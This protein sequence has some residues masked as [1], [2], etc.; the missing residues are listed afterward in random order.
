MVTHVLSG[1]V[2]GVEGYCVVVEADVSNGLPVFDIGGNLGPEVKE[3]RER[4]R[5][6]LKNI[7]YELP[8][9]RITVNFSPADRRKFGTAYDLPIAIAVLA[10]MKV[11]DKKVLEDTFFAG[12]LLLTGEV[13]RVNG[14]LP[15]VISAMRN[16]C[17]RFIIPKDN[18]LEGA[19]V[20]GAEI[21]GAD[22]LKSVVDFLLGKSS[23]E[24]CPPVVFD[25]E[26]YTK[27]E[28]NLSQIQGQA[29]A[30]RGIEV[31]AA[32]Y[33]NMLMIGPPGAGK[34]MIAKCIPSIL[35]P[36]SVSECMD[37]S[38]VYSVSGMLSQKGGIITRR[39]FVAPHHSISEPAMIGGGNYPRPGSVSLATKGV[40]FMDE[41]PEFSRKTLES[42]RQPLEDKSVRISRNLDVI[43]YPADFMLV[44][45]MNPCPCG[46]YPDMRKCSCTKAAR[47]RY[48]SKLSKPLLD[49]MDICIEVGKVLVHDLIKPES[50]E[51]SE[52]VAERVAQAQYIQ[53]ERFKDLPISFNSQMNNRQIEQFCH[54][55]ANESRTM[56]MLAGKYELSARGYYRVLRV[57]RTIADLDG[58]NEIEESHLYEAFRLKCNSEILSEVN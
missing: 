26:D 24:K 5:I 58:L 25:E 21:F 3:G 13:R 32:G 47:A 52:E 10:A 33:H 28:Y 41:F 42:L 53:N 1:G 56:E 23:I 29:F 57:A 44:A 4:V 7:G 2:H 15:M 16:G 39:P 40:L 46:A 37:I 20:P 50:A 36:L 19:I 17:R 35:P 30:R 43:E 38:A 18:E 31:A 45:A 54:L 6:A 27:Y 12:E 34:S 51:S 8:V 22:N 48:L 9:K 55:G 49:R 14:I 11:L